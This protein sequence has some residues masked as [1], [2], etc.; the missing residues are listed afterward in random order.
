MNALRTDINIDI[1]NIKPWEHDMKGHLSTFSLWLQS[2]FFPPLLTLHKW[3]YI[4]S[5]YSIISGLFFFPIHRY[6]LV[7]L[8]WGMLFF[9]HTCKSQKYHWNKRFF[10]L[11]WFKTMP[12]KNR[13]AVCAVSCFHIS[14]WVNSCSAL[15][16]LVDGKTRSH[17]IT[18]S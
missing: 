17:D 6:L 7:G 10:L 11:N 18:T 13:R 4:M 9:I 16:C 12:F 8:W 5:I 3:D 2:F 1:D 15:H 14:L